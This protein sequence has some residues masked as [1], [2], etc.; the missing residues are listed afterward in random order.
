MRTVNKKMMFMQLCSLFLQEGMLK[1]NLAADY[2]EVCRM[3]KLLGYEPV[4]AM[5]HQMPACIEAAKNNEPNAS[6]AR[7]APVSTIRSAHLLT[8]GLTE[9]AL[10]DRLFP[11]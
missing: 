4:A 10:M 8:A 2:S 6:K 1:H 9:T 5:Q 7:A 11:A 3:E